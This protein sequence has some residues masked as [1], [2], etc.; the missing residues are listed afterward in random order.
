MK[1][2]PLISAV[3]LV[4]G[5]LAFGAG[6]VTNLTQAALET[7]L[8]GGG[9]VAFG[10]SGTLPLTN[11]ITIKQ[12]TT[13]DANGRAVTISGGNAV[14]LFQLAS[15]VQFW[16]KGLILADG[17]VVGTN[18]PNTNPS[19][20]GGDASGAGFLNL[21]GTLI[22]TSCTLTNHSVQGG[23]AGSISGLPNSANTGNGG[24]ALGAAICSF[25]GTV[26]LTN[27]ILIASAAKGGDASAYPYSQLTYSGQAWGGAIYSERSK[28]N[29]I[30]VTMVDNQ[31][32]GG[33]QGNQ[34]GGGSGGR[35]GD[36]AGG[37]LFATNSVVLINE[38]ILQNNS[39]SG[40]S[41]LLV[42]AIPGGGC[43]DGLGGALFI[44]QDTFANVQLSLFS[45]NTATGG[46]G[47]HY[48]PCG[49]GRGGGILN[50]GTLHV[51]SCK[52]M[53]NQAQGGGRAYS[54]ADGQGGA[55][56]SSHAITVD[57]CSFVGNFATGGS[58]GGLSG[59]PGNGAGGAIWVTASLN[60]TNSTLTANGALG[61]GY[62]PGSSSGGG[63]FVTNGT[64]NLVN[65]TVALNGAY[66]TNVPPQANGPMQGG[67]LFTTNSQVTV[68]NSIIANS[69]SGGDVWGTN[70]DGGYN[71]CSDGTANFSTQGSLNMADPM[72]ST[73]S[74][75][76][77][78]TPTISLLAG[79]PARDAVP[80][81]FPPVDQRGVAR[82]QGPSADI[83]A[84]E[85]DFISSA[86]A[87]VSQ[88]L[89]GTV[90]AGS[91]ITLSVGAS[92]TPPLSYQW[93][94]GG[95]GL[96]GATQAS[97]SLSNVQAADA[98]VYSAVV[99]NMYGTA[100]SEGAVLGV[101]SKPLI[102]SQPTG[103]VIAPG[104]NA[105][106]IVSASGPSLAY[107]WWHGTMPVPG[108]TSTELVLS[109]A[110]AGAQ[111]NYFAVVTNF[112]GSITS[113]PAVLAFDSSVLSILVAPKDQTVEVGYPASFSVSVS[114]IP[115]IVYQWQHNG[116]ALPGATNS[117]LTLPSAKT[118]DVG[119]YSVIV[120]NGYDSLTSSSAQLTVTPGATPPVL[121]I[122]RFGQNVT[123]TFS[124]QAGR[125]YRLLESTNLVAW[126]S[127]STNSAVAAGPLQFVQPIGPIP[128]S[129][130]R[131]VTP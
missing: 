54:G 66:S 112:A 2:S 130:F 9:L 121:V 50:A 85:A 63:I 47:F 25:G 12:N 80:S 95:V 110:M 43:G 1:A 90:R 20:P 27:C 100:T 38:S 105:Q 103:L 55:L 74:Q 42:G 92:G 64:A 52:F 62:P 8:K 97:L 17:A 41:A 67:G 65:L 99:T 96:S 16:V 73:L 117:E 86:P 83:G 3:L 102:L 77:G 76:G 129:S 124:A 91:S 115:P 30:N 81:G 23:S 78:P 88:P 107:Q 108:A 119:S 4:S 51:T 46:N 10:V 87:I 39:V 53:A 122:G 49:S 70:V 13:L 82:P 19:L 116:L 69:E 104:G 35:F 127:L 109:N 7:A 44:A 40:A 6:T 123:I 111:G 61:V 106:F 72:L 128:V 59:V 94:K 24:K 93:L 71:I 131:V 18:G 34:G 98:A 125:S 21:G 28:V 58:G 15:N 5:G 56:F 113:A 32:V 84:F 126:I 36:G 29:L 26:N 14:R 48:Y 45:T 114:G 33:G 101:D 60:A 11:P 37:A 22:L 118:N 31:A 57:A 120:T 68:R 89:G 79:S 75:N